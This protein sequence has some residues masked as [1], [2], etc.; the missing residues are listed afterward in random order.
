[1]N[2][3]TNKTNYLIKIAL[4]ASISVILMYFEFPISPAFP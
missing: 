1:M 4:M 3:V 2:N